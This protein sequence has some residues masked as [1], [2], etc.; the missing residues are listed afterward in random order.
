MRWSAG[1]G[2]ACCDAR[3]ERVGLR[4][5][6]AER[7]GGVHHDRRRRRRLRGDGF[8]AWDGA[9]MRSVLAVAVGR[10]GGGGLVGQGDRRRGRR[11]R[12]VGAQ[13]GYR[14]CTLR[15]HWGRRRG[16]KVGFGENE[17]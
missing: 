5:R 2:G 9:L 3:F 16:V 1:G 8:S 11:G 13:G 7:L 4:L 12:L 6:G 14:G 17:R 10:F 15:L